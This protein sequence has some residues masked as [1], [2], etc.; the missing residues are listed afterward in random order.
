MSKAITI[1]AVAVTFLSL[2]IIAA[3][4]SAKSAEPS[5]PMPRYTISATGERAMYAD[6]TT[7]G[8]A[9][10]PGRTRRGP[11]SMFYVNR[12]NGQINMHVYLVNTLGQQVRDVR[13]VYSPDGKTFLRGE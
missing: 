8:Q 6:C 13:C 7:R 5:A 11:N 3:M 2:P 12:E 4:G 1:T 9:T 10:T